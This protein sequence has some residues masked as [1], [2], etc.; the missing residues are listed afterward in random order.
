MTSVALT[1]DPLPTRIALG[2]RASAGAAGDRAS[3]TAIAAFQ[4]A[5]FVAVARKE[6]A[7]AHGVLS[8]CRAVAATTRRAAWVA[9][10]PARPLASSRERIRVPR[11]AVLSGCRS[12]RADRTAIAPAARHEHRAC[13]RE[14]LAV[15]DRHRD[16]GGAVRG[17]VLA[18]D[19]DAV[20]SGRA[21]HAVRAH[22]RRA[23]RRFRVDDGAVPA[24]RF[25]V[26]AAAAVDADTLPE[27]DRRAGR[28]QAMPH[29]HRATGSRAVVDSLLQRLA[30]DGGGRAATA[31]VSTLRGDVHRLARPRRIRTT[32]DGRWRLLFQRW[33]FA[34]ATAARKKERER[35]E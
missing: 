9:G 3:G 34:T 32:A 1:N 35:A 6:A 15:A 4:P 29:E 23:G 24:V 8:T 2:T 10:R 21:V 12:C 30:G 27:S 25:A 22:R 16:A 31:A 7:T 11:A 5:R 26:E 14:P 13:Q 28:I 33:R 18:H 17:L 19:D 20:E